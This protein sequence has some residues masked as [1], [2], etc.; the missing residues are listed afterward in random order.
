MEA[1]I[2]GLNRRETRFCDHGIQHAKSS[3]PVDLS[4]RL[5]DHQ[6]TRANIGID[7]I[8]AIRFERQGRLLAETIPM[9]LVFP[10]PAAVPRALI[11]FSPTN[12]GGQNTVGMRETV[13]QLMLALSYYEVSGSQESGG[14]LRLEG[15]GLPVR[16]IMHEVCRERASNWER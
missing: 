7:D 10:Y 4:V 12:D 5:P 16:A 11:R 14:S 15:E 3:S 13:R 1:S 2:L 6:Y 9:G 8:Q